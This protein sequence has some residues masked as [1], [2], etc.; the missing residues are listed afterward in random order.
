MLEQRVL[1][2][3]PPGRSGGRAIADAETGRPLGVARRRPRQAGP[4]W[5]RL[6]APLW[7]VHEQE[8]DPLLF[9]VRRGWGLGPGKPVR[10]ADGHAVGAVGA[11]HVWDPAGGTLAVLEPGGPGERVFRGRGGRELARLAG[12]P[13]G[14]RVAFHPDVADPFLRMLLLAAALD[15]RQ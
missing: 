12:G 1:L 4:W 15:D 7:A 6:A 5:R 13:D 2:L 3:R 11:G 9:T 10:D 14:L 8:D